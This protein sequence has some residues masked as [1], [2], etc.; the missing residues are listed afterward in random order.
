MV[1]SLWKTKIANIYYVL[2]IASKIF[3]SIHIY[4]LLNSKVGNVIPI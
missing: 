3:I 1:S 4:N 2:G